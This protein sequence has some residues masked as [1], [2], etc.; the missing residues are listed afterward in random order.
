MPV[1]SVLE[2]CSVENSWLIGN[3]RCGAAFV[4]CCRPTSE[5]LHGT[6]RTTDC[7]DHLERRGAGDLQRW[8]RRHSS[9]Q[10]LALRCR[11]VLAFADGDRSRGEIAAELGCNPA[12]VTKWRH[13]FASSVSTGWWTRPAPERLA[14]SV[15]T[16]W[17][18]S[19]LRPSRA[20]RLCE[21][22]WLAGMAVLANY[23]VLK[24]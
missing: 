8:A 19:W 9:S 22:R 21:I 16:W 7:R 24:K 6:P 2:G 10:A 5:G 20:R 23:F 14:A 17:K 13:R 4:R 11:I 12:T 15:T 1:A 3:F 18:R